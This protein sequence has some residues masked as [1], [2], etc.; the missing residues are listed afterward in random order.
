MIAE[1]AADMAQ[2]IGKDLGGL[3]EQFLQL[4]EDQ[5]YQMILKVLKAEGV[6]PQDQ[7]EAELNQM[8]AVFKRNFLAM[9]NYTLQP[10][11]SRTVF[12]GAAEEEGADQL[13]REWTRWVE[14]KIEVHSVPGNHYSMIR[15]PHAAEIARQLK[16]HFDSAR[17]ES[18]AVGV[19]A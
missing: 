8:L 7:S 14:G 5:Q 19:E 6:L 9:E 13:P 2:L 12:F 18:G 11:A 3:S 1:F 16:Q 10:I 17:Q 15:Q 4:N